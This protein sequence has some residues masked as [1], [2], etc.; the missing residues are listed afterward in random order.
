[1][2]SA[3][4]G[5]IVAMP[6]PVTLPNSTLSLTWIG[7]ETP[8]V[9][10]TAFPPILTDAR[11]KDDLA[12]V[13]S[14]GAPIPVAI[15]AAPGSAAVPPPDHW[16]D[17]GR[18]AI[19]ERARRSADDFRREPEAARGRSLME[20]AAPLSDL[21]ATVEGPITAQVSGSAEVTVKVIVEASSSLINATANGGRASMPLTSGSTG[22]VGLQRTAATPGTGSG[23][24]GHQ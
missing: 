1:M 13:A 24:I 19:E 21:K 18:Q 20:H 12:S 5:S 16:L 8:L 15:V 6:V 3:W 4:N 10:A 9:H 17:G 2:H 14:R 23:G 22:G 11:V 7:T